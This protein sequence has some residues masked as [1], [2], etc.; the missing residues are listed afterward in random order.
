MSF[1]VRTF[2]LLLALVGLMLA[3]VMLSRAIDRTEQDAN[4]AYELDRF[5][6]PW[7]PTYRQTNARIA[8][9]ERG[10]KWLIWA[11]VLPTDLALI[12]SALVD[13]LSGRSRWL[14]RIA[15]FTGFLAAVLLVLTALASVVPSGSMIG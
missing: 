6:N 10:R 15:L 4:A 11:G 2:A 9:M 8:R 7:Y 12:T 13:L 1:P 14:A 3:V 5:G